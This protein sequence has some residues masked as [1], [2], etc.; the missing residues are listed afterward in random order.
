[1]NNMIELKLLDTEFENIGVTHTRHVARA[2]VLEDNKV[3]ILQ[4]KRD[5][6]FG[7]AT[8]LETSGG[9][10]DAG[11]TPEIAVLREIDEE[12]GVKGEIITK[13]GI[14]DDYYNK[15]KRHNINH[16]YLVKVVGKTKIHHVSAGDSLINQILKLDFDEI[17]DEYKNNRKEKITRLV[18]NRE[19]P[20]LKEAYRY[21]KEENK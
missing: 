21:L 12:L 9:G 4:V 5:D 11:E 18:Y 17:F 13:L 6:E 2:V 19:E 1:M 3:V 10:V 20:I 8:Y 14:I 16:Y 15:I 7:D